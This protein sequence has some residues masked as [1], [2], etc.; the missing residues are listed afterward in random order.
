MASFY[1]SNNNKIILPSS[2]LKSATKISRLTLKYHYINIFVMLDSI[3]ELTS[4]KTSRPDL[5][6]HLARLASFNFIWPIL[7]PVSFI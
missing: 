4:F 5:M 7:K 6:P 1:H 2:Q 3:L